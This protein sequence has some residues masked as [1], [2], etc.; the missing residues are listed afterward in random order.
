MC[1]LRIAFNE[2]YLNVCVGPARAHWPGWKE[3]PRLPSSEIER[4]R[5]REGGGG[6]GRE[7]EREIPRQIQYFLYVERNYGDGGKFLWN[8]LTW[9]LCNGQSCKCTIIACYYRSVK[10]IKNPWL[11][12]MGK[13]FDRISAFFANHTFEI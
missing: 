13:F 6:G 10:V 7:R 3:N 8:T 12:E 9:S 5:E 2:T 11:Y 4:E 1:K